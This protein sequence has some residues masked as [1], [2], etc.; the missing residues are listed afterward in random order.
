MV[1]GRGK[2]GPLILVSGMHRS[3]TSLLGSLLP[4]L[5]VPVPG[6]LVKADSHNP[7]GYY[8]HREVVNVQEQLLIELGRWWPSATG[9]LPLPADWLLRPSSQHTSAILRQ[10]IQVETA[11]QSGPWAIKDPRTSLLLPL[12]RRLA[13]A[14]EVS[15]KVVLC[16]R[17][18]AEVMMSLLQRDSAAA[19]MTP[20]RAQQLWWHNNRQLLLDS[21]SLPL[22]VIDY[23]AWFEPQQARRQLER[24]TRFCGRPM[25]AEPDAA[26][27]V[28][29]VRPEHRR[30]LLPDHALPVPIAPELL[31]LTDQLRHLAAPETAAQQ[32]QLD[33]LRADLLPSS[34]ALLLEPLR[35]LDRL[36]AAR[37]KRQA[38]RTSPGT[39]GGW[40]DPAHYRSQVGDLPTVIDPLSHYRLHGWREDRSPHPLFDPAFYRQRCLQEGLTCEGAPLFHFLQVGLARGVAP[41]ALMDQGWMQRQGV[42]LSPSEPP[43]RLEQIHPLGRA[44]QALACGHPHLGAALLAQWLRLGLAPLDQQL[45][46]SAHPALPWPAPSSP[47]PTGVGGWPDRFRLL[48]LG[49]TPDQWWIHAWLQRLPVSASAV[50]EALAADQVSLPTVGLSL[51]NLPAGDWSLAALLGWSQLDRVLDPDPERVALFRRLGVNAHWLAS[52]APD[53]GWLNQPGD[54]DAASAELGAPHPSALPHGAVLALGTTGEA[55]ERGLAAPIWGWPGFDAL[56]IKDHDQARLLASWLQA[57]Q[58]EGLQLLRLNP[59]Q[60]ERMVGIFDPLS[61]PV[62]APLGWL[63]GQ[64]FWA[65]LHPRA[66]A[67]E[68]AW[69]AAGCPPPPPC[70]TPRPAATQLWAQEAEEAGFEPASAA[71]CISL[72]NYASRITEA[73]ESVAAQSHGPLELI[74][75]DDASSD[76]GAE[77]VRQ[78]LKAHATRFTRSVLLQH[79]ANGGL[80]AARNTAFTAARSPWCFVLDADNALLPD[81]VTHCLA[82]TEVT[83]AETAV[84]HP[85]VEVQ[86][87]HGSTDS[88]TLISGVSWQRHQFLKQNCID[89]MALVRR[90]AWQAVGG[91]THIEGGWEDFDFWCCLVDA[92]FHGVLCPQ[93]LALY[94]SHCS[95][96]LASSTNSDVRRISRVLQHRHPWLQLPMAA[97]EC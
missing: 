97:P 90:S 45:I 73:L 46:V 67:A 10:L 18:P 33:Q 37:L 84:V 89:A 47:S 82:I 31:K 21:R 83:P 94:R 22:L 6:D 3:G 72:Y 77:L 51:L 23:A 1:V 76:G 39:P 71:V 61:W 27:V 65:P 86:A 24:L 96:M 44:A 95:S 50:G 12:W 75:V 11:R 93:R 5:G 42:R 13:A 36:R 4:P 28:A 15:L 34:R 66:V 58:L 30:S 2:A 19:G 20:W 29:R 38:R 16:L 92:G 87:E 62:D 60:K 68:L 85:L 64:F 79:S 17:D 81:A 48:L 32:N 7:E 9:P 78:W 70:A 74:V 26:E 56:K 52:S 43:A 49:A 63:P 91:Y 8:E 35:R 69:R 40:F 53:N 25:P 41:S 55:W 59:S 54:L 57:C 80:A 14:L 88:R